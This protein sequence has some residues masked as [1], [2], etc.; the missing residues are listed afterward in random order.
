MAAR[1][2][3][4]LYLATL[5]FSLGLG[6]QAEPEPARKREK[7]GLLLRSLVLT[8]VVLPAVAWGLTRLWGTSR[9]TTQAILLLAAA[10]GGRYA[11]QLASMAKASMSISIEMTLWLVKLTVFTAPLTIDWLLGAGRIRLPELRL[12][13]QLLLAQVLPLYLGK[14]VRKRR[15]AGADTLHRRIRIAMNVFAV[16]TLVTIAAMSGTEGFAAL[17]GRGWMAFLSLAAISGGLGWLIG[18]RSAGN[19]RAVALGANAHNL[20][21]ALMIEET[22][23]SLAAVRSILLGTWLVFFAV[24]TIFAQVLRRSDERSTRHM[25]LASGSPNSRKVWV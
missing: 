17:D 23:A 12:V 13:A 10:P 11:P 2:L 21:L 7:Y 4:V 19:R 20:A 16:A 15:G 5:M 24:N 8:I 1:I 14:A 22:I 3:V 9:A 6:F 18:G 25:T